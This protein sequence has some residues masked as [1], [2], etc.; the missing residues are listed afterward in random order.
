[1]VAYLDATDDTLVI[2]KCDGGNAC[3]YPQ[4]SHK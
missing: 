4:P 3:A 2:I 1:V